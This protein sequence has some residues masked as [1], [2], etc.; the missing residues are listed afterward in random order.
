MIRLQGVHGNRLRAANDF[1][2]LV[3]ALTHGTTGNA[4]TF[5]TGSTEEPIGYGLSK[6]NQYIFRSSS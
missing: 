6:K 4:G 5:T 1:G 2:L 3:Q